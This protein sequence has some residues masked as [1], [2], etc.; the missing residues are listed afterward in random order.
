MK[1]LLAIVLCLAVAGG[2]ATT[3][4]SRVI[5]IADGDTLKMPAMSNTRSASLASTRQR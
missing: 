1:S 2:Y 3:L 5:K 4:T